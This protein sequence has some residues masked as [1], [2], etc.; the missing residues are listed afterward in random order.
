M[1]FLS[2]IFFKPLLSV[3]KAEQKI[4]LLAYNATVYTAGKNFSERE[5][6]AINNGKIITARTA[7]DLQNGLGL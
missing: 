4:D 5:A 1:K 6:K 7:K 2:V 3:A